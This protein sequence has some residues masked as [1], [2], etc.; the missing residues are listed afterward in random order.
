MDH[1]DD[2]YRT[3]RGMG[4]D[5]RRVSDYHSHMDDRR[6]SG[7]EIIDR[8]REVCKNFL[9]GRCK[10]GSQCP[11]T[12]ASY[13]PETEKK[14][15]CRDFQRGT[16]PRGERS[17]P[18]IH[19]AAGPGAMMGG[20]GGRDLGSP[21]RRMGGYSSSYSPPHSSPIS[22]RGGGGG[23]YPLPLPSPNIGIADSA[24]LKNGRAGPEVCRDF[25]YRKNCARGKSCPYL[26]VALDDKDSET[27]NKK[28]K[29]ELTHEQEEL[30]REN[31]LLR[32]EN[33]T[34]EK[35]NNQLRLENDD[36]KQENSRLRRYLEDMG[37]RSDD[38][39]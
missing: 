13:I 11:Y 38:T 10:K 16:C 22:T 35:E 24:T 39:P 19:V 5:A 12:H 8:R 17:C 30:Q 7:P 9:L 33:D 23:G 21:P 15:V 6:S 37:G 36:F 14:E 27:P 25:L 31:R 20:M 26:H 32:D 3:D 18:F 29:G 28:R 1:H 34:I 2:Y 4:H